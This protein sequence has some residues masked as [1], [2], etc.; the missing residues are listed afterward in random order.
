MVNALRLDADGTVEHGLTRD[1]RGDF[2]ASRLKSRV[3]PV[4]ANRIIPRGFDMTDVRRRIQANQTPQQPTPI[5]GIGCDAPWKPNRRGLLALLTTSGVSLIATGNPAHANSIEIP[6]AKEDGV[7]RVKSRIDLKGNAILPKDPLVPD[8]KQQQIPIQAEVALDFE[9]RGHVPAQSPVGTPALG[10]DRKY[11]EAKSVS[12]VGKQKITT[13]LRPSVRTVIARRERL[14][15][16]LY[17][18]DDYLSH[19]EVDLLRTPLASISLEQLIAGHTIEVDRAIQPT[20]SSV[21]SA[22]NLSG[23]EESDLTITPV[24]VEEDEIRFELKGKVSGFVSGVATTQRLVGKMSYDRSQKLIHW[25]A[26]AIHEKR[27]IGNAEPG[28]D[29]AATIRMVRGRMARTSALP[30]SRPTIDFQ[31]P[32]P[33]ERLLTQH[34]VD[35]ANIA[36]LADR[37]WR[38]LKDVSGHAMMR[39]IDDDHTIAQCDIRPLAKLPAGQQWTMDAFEKDVRTSLQGQLTQLLQGRQS[40]T[41]TGLR[42][43][44]IT[45]LGEVEGVPMQWVLTHLSDDT[46]R[47]LL[48]TLTMDAESVPRLAGTD[49]QL[50]ASLRL[51]D[52]VP[53]RA[54]TVESLT[55]NTN[56]GDGSP[57]AGLDLGIADG[58][59]EVASASDLDPKKR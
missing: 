57:A 44:Q 31:R 39:M 49:V 40:L 14:P 50:V 19:E 11:L 52:G 37:R 33:E 12:F 41:D 26:V 7:I 51:L 1:R 29:I 32:V 22:L 28:F 42:S 10:L 45:A 36:L 46:G 30:A 4:R 16:V 48:V 6:A 25:A 17:S 53:E 59:A 38:L 3:R 43:L 24:A 54:S 13:E 58:G 15:E 18:P 27:E 2:E 5:D 34:T 56:S 55:S 21:A 9:Q 23:V 35:A 20:P 47:R 8:A